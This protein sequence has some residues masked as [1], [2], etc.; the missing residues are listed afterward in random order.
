MRWLILAAGVSLLM[1][2]SSP[3]MKERNRSG[4]LLASEG[5]VRFD[6][7]VI[8]LARRRAEAENREFERWEETALAECREPFLPFPEDLLLREFGTVCLVLTLHDAEGEID[9]VWAGNTLFINVQRVEF[10]EFM[11]YDELLRTLYRR[12]ADLFPRA[13]WLSTLP[14]GF[15]YS[16]HYLTAT[17]T[18][19]ISDHWKEGFASLRARASMEDDFESL[20]SLLCLNTD[21]EPRF[22]PRDERLN[23]KAELVREFLQRIDSRIDMPSGQV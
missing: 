11:V 20:A 10:F 22:G 16:D 5:F 8:E 13:E 14:D 15:E 18:G 2:C 19:E 4:E 3:T 12:Y 1:G 17:V 9:A 23:R 21:W 7:S 6:D